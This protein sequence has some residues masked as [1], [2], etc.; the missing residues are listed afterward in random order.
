MAVFT[1]PKPELVERAIFIFDFVLPIQ[2]AAKVSGESHPMLGGTISV[3][4][5][6]AA[7][8]I[9]TSPAAASVWPTAPLTEKIGRGVGRAQAE[10]GH[11][12][13]VA[14]L[15]SRAV[16]GDEADVSG[17]AISHC[18]GLGNCARQAGSVAIRRGH[19]N[20]VGC[21]APAEDRSTL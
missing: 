17:L 20:G 3:R 6:R 21:V 11:L 14:V 18:N 8:R 7:T 5:A 10:G 1:P 9:C 16:G 13:R 2:S 19:V 12:H 15:R 4:I